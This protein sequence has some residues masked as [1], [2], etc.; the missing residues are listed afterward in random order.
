M[1]EEKGPIEK[2]SLY[3]KEY[4]QKTKEKFPDLTITKQLES[5]KSLE[6]IVIGDTIVDE[7]VFAMPKGRAIKD[8]ILSLDFIKSERYPGGILAIANH[9]AGFVGTLKLIT[10][11]G[12]YSREEE[13]VRNNLRPNITPTFF[14]KND[15]PTTI[16]KR[17]IDDIRKSKLFK[18]EHI[19]D[20]PLD[21]ETED[22]VLTYLKKEL[23]N[24]NLVV[25]GDFGH[26]F[27]TDNIARILEE[28]SKFLAGN[29][30]TNSSNIGFNY[31][32][33]YNRLDYLTSNEK[34]IRFAMLDRFGSFDDL[35]KKLKE[36]TSFRNILITL[37]GDGC[38][39]IKNDNSYTGP[40]F[41]KEVKDAVGAGDAVFAITSL[42][43]YKNMDEELLVFLANCVGVIAVNI[44]GNQTSVTKEGLLKLIREL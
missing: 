9:I 29:I 32:T 23:P 12:E 20:R 15:S 42:L 24:Y 11:L 3:L 7:Y 13:F 25:L 39:Y 1:T 33:K 2:E 38:L 18:V 44:M 19:N 16:K 6:A 26:G 37:G 5:L 8:P 4:L 14:T 22:R 35:I 28:D 41:T 30:Q 36:R 10:A 34:E 27:I 31:I 17:Y 21:K 43:S 40:A